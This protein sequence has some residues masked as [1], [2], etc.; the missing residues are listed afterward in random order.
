MNAPPTLL[1]HR[2]R[3]FHQLGSLVGGLCGG[4][5][6]DLLFKGRRGPI[7]V[8]FSAIT[9]P[10]AMAA[11]QPLGTG[12]VDMN[13]LRLIYF[14]LGF[15]SFAPHMLIGLTA[16][17][18]TPRKLHSSAG[19]FAKAAG[20]LGGAFAGYPLTALAAHYGWGSVTWAFVVS[21]VLAA[22]SFLPLWNMGAPSQLKKRE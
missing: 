12:P 16:R 17:E 4:I 20:Q 1:Y 10:F 13:T 7:M 2:F 14:M 18:L 3:A 15:F 9:V 19:C 8:L 6:S 21:G 22:A 5:V 11:T